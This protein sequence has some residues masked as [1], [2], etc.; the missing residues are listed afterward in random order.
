MKALCDPSGACLA[1]RILE[2]FGMLLHSL[3]KESIGQNLLPRMKLASI[4]AI[5][6]LADVQKE[7]T[8]AWLGRW[9]CNYIY[10]T[11]H[12]LCGLEYLVSCS[13]RCSCQNSGNGS[14]DDNTPLL[15]TDC[16]LTYPALTFLKTHQNPGGGWGETLE[17]YR[18]LS[19]AGIGRSTPSQTTWALMGLLAHL[20]PD[21]QAII[22]GIEWLVREQVEMKGGGKSWKKTLHTGAG[23]DNLP[24]QFLLSFTAPKPLLNRSLEFP[25]SRRGI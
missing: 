15:Q 13:P 20:P 10:S 4:R 17:P 6:F 9:G 19:L 8:G 7:K 3:D 21:D 12:V 18:D 25:S 11:S 1:G 16:D 14:S 2:A 22:K 23:L 5:E 24:S